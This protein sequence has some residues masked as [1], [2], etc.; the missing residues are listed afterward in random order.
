MTDTSRS[1]DDFAAVLFDLDG[2]ITSTATV[3]AAAWKELFDG[4]LEARDGSDF[5]P[6]DTETD[7]KPYVDGKPRY[8]GV[9][10][11]LESRDIHLPFG[12]PDDS[13]DAE[14]C[15]GL[16][17]KK[18]GYFRKQLAEKGAVVFAS[19]V[20]WVRE[21][22]AKG[23]KTAVVSS[24]KN[25]EAIL[26]KAGIADLFDLRLDGVVAEKEKIPGKPEPDT[27][28]EAARRL[29]V[30]PKDAVVI[31][32][33]IS[34][35]MAGHAGGFGLVIGIDRDHHPEALAE[36]GADVVVEDLEEIRHPEHEGGD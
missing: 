22:R 18:N 24:S 34:G 1:P 25:C 9:R 17:N 32:D 12:T 20:A 27:F 10:S 2:V 3:H 7:Y 29:G 26:D 14:T 11:F 8:E 15:C 4:Y 16:G 23:V 33:A 19:T 28:V 36:H 21:L 13:P 31:E 6:F 30:E 5:V 35:V